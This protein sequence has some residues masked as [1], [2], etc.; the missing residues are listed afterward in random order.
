MY[1]KHHII[2]GLVF[3]VLLFLLFPVIGI[4]GALIVF[5]SSFLIDVDHYIG[6]AIK[7]KDWNLK[8]AIK[9]H[10]NHLDEVMK[11]SRA[12]R[13]IHPSSVFFLHGFEVL[14]ILLLL[15]ILVSK[16]FFFV[17]TG[18]T[19]HLMLD[20]IYATKIHDRL[21]KLSIIYDFL[22]FKKL[23]NINDTKKKGK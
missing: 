6:Y 20:T 7:N 19:F 3:S 18:F 23:R 2:F 5:F 21:D 8:N 15:S 16:L 9:W 12:K 14:L 17:L 10:S 1:A 4:S 11:M 13:N 22:K